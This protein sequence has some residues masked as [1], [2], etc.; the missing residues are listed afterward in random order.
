MEWLLSD[1]YELILEDNYFKAFSSRIG[2]QQLARQMNQLSENPKDEG[3]DNAGL[4]INNTETFNNLSPQL[5]IMK[6]D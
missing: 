5:D 4:L 6:R 3:F 2:G 1:D